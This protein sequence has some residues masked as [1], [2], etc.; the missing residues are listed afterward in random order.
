[1]PNRILVLTFYYPPDLCAGS[2]RSG[3]LVNALCEKLDDDTLVDVITTMPNRYQSYQREADAVETNGPV[4]VYRLPVAPHKS[5]FVDQARSFLSYARRA[6]PAARARD[7]DLV[8]AT[9]S[10]LMTA[11]LG[12]VISRRK[13]ALLYLDIRD[14]FTD[15]MH[16]VLAGRISYAILP[17]FRALE[18]FT[19]DSA[20]VINVV[21][22]GFREYFE[23]RGFGPLLRFHTNGI[24]DEFLARDFTSR[25][26]AGPRRRIL[27]AG[28]IGEGQGLHRLVPGA[29]ELLR[30]THEIVIVGDGG[31][32]DAL[33]DACSGLD[34]VRIE[35]PVDREALMSLYAAADV[36]LMHLNDFQ[37]FRKVLPSKIFEYGATGKPILAG[38]AGYAAEFTREF[39]ENAA[40][41]PP[42]DAH[43]MAAAL[44]KLD[45][46][47]TPRERFIKEF[48]RESIMSRMA[49]DVA[50]MLDSQV[51]QPSR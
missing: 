12:A 48:A 34:N 5:G 51:L 18:K 25:S 35:P 36:L 28:N 42:C 21:S 46:S 17:I 10:R 7:Y 24:D 16:E 44:A 29:A 38:V 9:S 3:A 11:A 6:L 14:L 27:Y 45:T 23:K 1:M 39:V 43:A 8:Y 41:F 32:R 37:A 20:D 19:F 26:D 49:T 15:T 33:V 13:G 30:D 22:P 4:T 47:P 31:A 40:V 50:E 2:F